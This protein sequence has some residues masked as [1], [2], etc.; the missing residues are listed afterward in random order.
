MVD[1]RLADSLGAILRV[2]TGFIYSTRCSLDLLKYLRIK[3]FAIRHSQ[4]R[5]FFTCNI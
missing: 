1:L 3:E 5:H 4:I 2:Y